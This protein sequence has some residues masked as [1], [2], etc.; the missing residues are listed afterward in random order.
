VGLRYQPSVMNL[1][2]D[3]RHAKAS[4]S[5]WICGIAS[6]RA[7][8]QHGRRGLC[9]KIWRAQEKRTAREPRRAKAHAGTHGGDVKF[10]LGR[11]I[12]HRNMLPVLNWSDVQLTHNMIDANSDR[13]LAGRVLFK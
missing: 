11:S 5:L 12:P 7:L 1:E 8:D 6:L 2:A 3:G 13:F 10:I 9:L 4:L